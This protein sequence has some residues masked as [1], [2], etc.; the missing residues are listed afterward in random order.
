MILEILVFIFFLVLILLHVFQCSTIEGATGTIAAKKYQDPGL[1][2]NPLYLATVNA[3]NISYLKDQIGEA[4][5]AQG[6]LAA[7]EDDIT[8]LELG[9]EN[10]ADPDSAAGVDLADDEEED[11]D[12]DIDEDE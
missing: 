4:E 5:D 11:I 7:M 3:A 6:D 1:S 2:K 10:I 8:A 12:F 9:L